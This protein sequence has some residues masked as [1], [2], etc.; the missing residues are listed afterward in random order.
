MVEAFFISHPPPFPVQKRS[1]RQ[2]SCVQMRVS[3]AG[4]SKWPNS[5]TFGVVAASSAILGPLL[6][7]YHSQFGVLKYNN[8]IDF[9]AQ[10]GT[11]AMHVTTA[12]F[13]PPLFVVAGLII[14]LG[15]VTL[16]R[17]FAISVLPADK[18]SIP[19]A[20]AT[21]SMFCSIYYLSAAIPTSVCADMTGPLLC[22]LSLLEWYYMDRSVGGL[23]MGLLTGVCGPLL[24]MG[25]INVGELYSYTSPEMFGV[26]LFIFPV[27]FAGGPA[28]GN[29]ARAI[30][31]ELV[32]RKVQ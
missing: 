23:V 14:A 3:K 6:D 21:V 19:R 10:V 4:T 11:V 22:V 13:T 26:P 31:D 30:E 16:N 9:H 27:Y 12:G 24:E 28:V 2:N 17:M 25:L 8:P 18:I 32:T 15:T 20:L 29:L 1:M 7:N 5:R